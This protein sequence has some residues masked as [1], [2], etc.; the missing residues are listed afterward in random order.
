MHDSDMHDSE[1]YDDLTTSLITLKVILEDIDK[2]KI[3]IDLDINN[4]IKQL[5]AEKTDDLELLED[6]L[7]IITL[8]NRFLGR[9]NNIE[10]EL[11]LRRQTKKKIDNIEEL[12]EEVNEWE[13]KSAKML[14][15]LNYAKNDKIVETAKIELK[16]KRLRASKKSI[17][18]LKKSI[19]PKTYQHLVLQTKK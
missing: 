14:Q 18:F 6:E 8:R 9:P 13:F 5:E 11:D 4:K 12:K 7:R 16:L 17:K 15:D 1:I 2:I 19:I 3:V 10:E